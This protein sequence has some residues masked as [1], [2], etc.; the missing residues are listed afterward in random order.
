MYGDQ[1]PPGYLPSPAPV[2]PS[3]PQAA[4]QLWYAQQAA[5]QQQ[6]QQQPMPGM[7]GMP[8]HAPVM[9]APPPPMPMPAPVRPS[10]PS[11]PRRAPTPTPPQPEPGHPLWT[12]LLCFV[13]G[14]A[15]GHFTS[16]EPAA[17]AVPAVVQQKV[18]P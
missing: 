4:M 6:Q 18:S 11:S 17:P 3:D 7:Y 13:I 1:M 10:R 12:L 8:M 9:P 5:R 2:D 14:W 15:F 16:G